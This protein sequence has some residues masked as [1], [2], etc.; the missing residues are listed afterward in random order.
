MKNSWFLTLVRTKCPETVPNSPIKAFP[1]KCSSFERASL[2]NPSNLVFLVWCNNLDC[3]RQPWQ[4]PKQQNPGFNLIFS[5]FQVVIFCIPAFGS[6]KF[7]SINC[8]STFIIFIF[9][10][11]KSHLSLNRWTLPIQQSCHT[12][13]CLTLLMSVL[14]KLYLHSCFSSSKKDLSHQQYSQARYYLVSAPLSARKPS[15]LFRNQW[16]MSSHMCIRGW[17]GDFFL[18]IAGGGSEVE[19]LPE[20]GFPGEKP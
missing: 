8:L 1:W 11:E 19:F 12:L 16:F 9:L 13:F 20:P 5:C 7:S 10:E 17:L 2:W 18:E 14:P 6:G 4:P 3:T 15:C